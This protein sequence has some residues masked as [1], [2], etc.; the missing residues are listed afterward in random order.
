MFIK[1][2][3]ARRLVIFRPH[4]HQPRIIEPFKQCA[5]VSIAYES[6]P[7]LDLIPHMEV[8]HTEWG[9]VKN[10]PDPEPD[11]VIV[12][13][14]FV[15]SRIN[16]P[17]VFS[18]GRHVYGPGPNGKRQ[19]LGCRGLRST[20]GMPMD[21]PPPEED[22]ANPAE[23]ADHD[24]PSTGSSLD[25][26]T[27][28]PSPLASDMARRLDAYKEMNTVDLHQTPRLPQYHEDQ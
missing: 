27:P 25:A 12:V 15:A 13:P 28:C 11:T 16:R 3:T 20:A 22:Y 9:V 26:W 14:A 4:P 10:L 18:P 21:I 19:V 8:F 24:E 6:S 17:D 23:L 1:N 7:D 5:M 2:L